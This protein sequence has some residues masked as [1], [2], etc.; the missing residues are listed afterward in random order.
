MVLPDERLQ[1]SWGGTLLKFQLFVVKGFSICSTF[2]SSFPQKDNAIVISQRQW[3]LGRNTH[4]KS[5]MSITKYSWIPH[6]VDTKLAQQHLYLVTVLHEFCQ[7]QQSLS[8]FCNILRSQGQLNASNQLVLLVFIQFR[9][10]WNKSSIEE[11]SGEEHK[12]QCE[13]GIN[14]KKSVWQWAHLRI[15][16]KL[17]NTLTCLPAINS[18]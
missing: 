17:K 2:G 11:V 18:D 13:V 12:R 1:N 8:D 16:T 3:A 15:Q 10:A 6:R 14:E 7:V 9:P 4:I 5:R